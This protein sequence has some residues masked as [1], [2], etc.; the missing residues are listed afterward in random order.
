MS[1]AQFPDAA[2]DSSADLQIW[3]NAAFDNGEISE[4]LAASKQS[5]GS[6]KSIFGN[7]KAS[8][9]SVSGK[10][11]QG[12]AS[13]N[14]IPS[15]PKSAS[16]TPFKPLNAVESVEKSKIREIAMNKSFEQNPVSK[17]DEEIEEIE[18]QILRLNSRLE[19]L[20]VEKASVRAAER[21]GRSVAAKF[22][23]QKQSVSKNAEIPNSNSNL[24]ARTK[25]SRR[26]ISLGPAE[27]LSAGRRGM[28]LGPSEIFGAAK[29]RQVMM[30]TPLQSS[31]RKS[32]LLKLPEIDEERVKSSSLSPKSRKVAAGKPR[33]AAT[34]I[35]SKKAVK[36]EDSVMS[37]VQPKK[38][39]RDGEKSA[40]NKKAFR[41]GRVVAS[42]YNQNNASSS[43]ASA[44]RKRSLPDYDGDG[45]KRVEK[46]RSLSP[47]KTRANESEVRVKKRWEIPSE[48][49][50]HGSVEG[51]GERSPAGCVV[52]APCLLP[53]LRIARCNESPRDSGPAKKVAELVG[54]RSYFASDEG[55]EVCQ[56]L[57]YE[58][59]EEC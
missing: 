26:G 16:T 44:M 2:M 25:V 10:E 48:I 23:E 5:W 45:G 15:F 11:N 32:C 3:N 22:M 59:E 43:Q 51:E 57:S 38:L 1:V 37:S 53:R 28:S 52:A 24:S 9:D 21:K 14:Q 35:G 6:L 19:S 12:F 36:K 7:A 40:P 46:K 31:R 39:F 42:R 54:R 17:I 47:G 33:Q 18:S 13:E 55:V 50:V 4:D 29:S 49:V 20:K 41:P 56:A 8:F 30:N 27:I 34:T 58:E